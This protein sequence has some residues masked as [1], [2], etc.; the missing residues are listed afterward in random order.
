MAWGK[1]MAQIGFLELLN[2][3]VYL[4]GK[5]YAPVEIDADVSSGESHAGLERPWRGLETGH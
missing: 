2:L 3:Y 5:R 4:D 1:A